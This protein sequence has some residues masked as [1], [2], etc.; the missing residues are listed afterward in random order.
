VKNQPVG[1]VF[2][3]LIDANGC[4][5]FANGYLGETNSSSVCLDASPVIT[6]NG[7]S[8]NDDLEIFC[9]ENYPNNKVQ[10][11]N[12]WGQEILV[13]QNYRNHDWKGTYENG[14]P[15]PNGAYFYVVEVFGDNPPA[16]Q[17]GSFVILNE[18]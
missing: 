7:D 9:L 11:F 15:V 6:P 3:M 1:R 12:R 18:E 16:P 5:S 8:Y 4:E 2:V 13:K 14:T 10:I 17:K